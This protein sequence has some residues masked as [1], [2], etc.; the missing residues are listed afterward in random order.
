[1]TPGFFQIS[2][3]LFLMR[4][5]ELLILRDRASKYGDLPGGRLGETEIYLPFP[6]SLGREIRELS[7]YIVGNILNRNWI[8]NNSIA[9]ED[10]LNGQTHAKRKMRD[11]YYDLISCAVGRQSLC[12]RHSGIVVHVVESKRSFLESAL[13]NV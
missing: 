11:L 5:D 1:M 6:E 4:G 10:H 9:Y 3:K 8:R 2:L 13:W 7:D 12:L